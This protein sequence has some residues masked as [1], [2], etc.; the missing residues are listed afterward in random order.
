MSTIQVTDRLADEDIP[1]FKPELMIKLLATLDEN[2]HPNLVLIISLEAKDNDTLMFAEFLKGK[3]KKNVERNPKCTAAFM[4]LG[5]DYWV[6]KGDF[7]HWSYEGPEYE[8]YNEKSLFKNNAYFGIT[9]VGYIDIK[10]VIPK[11]KIKVQRP[12]IRLI[13]GYIKEGQDKTVKPKILPLLVEKIFRAPSNLKYIAFIDEDGYPLIVPTMHLLPT[14][15]NQLVFTAAEFQEDLS[16]LK[17][18]M[19]VTAFAMNI[20]ELLMYQIKGK[21]QGTQAYQESKLNIIA[22]EEIYCLMPPRAG[23]RIV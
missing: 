10:Q 23:D 5:N 13:K 21:Y 2:Q 1:E 22:I 12:L 14:P 4:S 20:E 16:H 18:G 11:R 15:T 9:R 17:E 3:T 19:F 7:T 8:Y 6:V